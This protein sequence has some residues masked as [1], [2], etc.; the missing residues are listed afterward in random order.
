[1]LVSSVSIT[2]NSLALPKYYTI[3]AMP[4]KQSRTLWINMFYCIQRMWQ[5][6]PI[7]E[8]QNK[9]LN[10][11]YGLYYVI[12][13]INKHPVLFLFVCIGFRVSQITK[14]WL[15][16]PTSYTCAINMHCCH[17]NDVIMGTIASQVTSLPIVFST[18]YSDADQRKHQS[19]ASLAFVR[20]IHRGPVNSPHNWPV[21]RKMFPFDDVIMCT[22]HW[23]CGSWEMW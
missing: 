11:V 20:G 15:C 1:M 12:Y 23:V 7:Q 3:S 10:I 2:T 22:G 19:S 13:L 4:V 16:L 14:H 5:L 6:Q 17:Y 9:T 21:T 8:K 18:V